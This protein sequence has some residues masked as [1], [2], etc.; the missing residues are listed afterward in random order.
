MPS[1]TAPVA[2]WHLHINFRDLVTNQ[3]SGWPSKHTQKRMRCI[4]LAWRPTDF[5]KWARTDGTNYRCTVCF[6]L[7]VLCF[8]KKDFCTSC[9]WQYGKIYALFSKLSKIKLI[10][11]LISL[12]ITVS[13]Q[14]GTSHVQSEIMYCFPHFLL[15]LLFYKVKISKSTCYHIP[16]KWYVFTAARKYFL[17]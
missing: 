14:S 6:S 13:P 12:D 5:N 2:R 7:I 8:F 9:F 11:L 16:A 4:Y 15:N 1:T 17:G 3:S 10:K